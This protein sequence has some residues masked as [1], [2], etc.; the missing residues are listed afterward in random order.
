[1]EQACHVQTR[2]GR[3]EYRR[4][5]ASSAYRRLPGACL[6]AA[7]AEAGEN[8]VRRPSMRALATGSFVIAAV[9]LLF[10]SPAY[11]Q[12]AVAGIVRDS[13]GA[14]LPGV[15]VEAASPALIEK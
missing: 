11:S 10:S 6:A 13:S 15:S 9:L 7:L 1:M 3:V 14:I 8:T 4:L 2:I 12:G 5:I